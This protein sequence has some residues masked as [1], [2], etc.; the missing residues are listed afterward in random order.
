MAAF[1]GVPRLLL[2]NIRHPN[3]RFSTA[4]ERGYVWR[5]IQILFLSPA[6][7]WGIKRRRG[8]QKPLK[9]PLLHF[10]FAH[11]TEPRNAPVVPRL[12]TWQLF[13]SFMIFWASVARQVK[14]KKKEKKKNPTNPTLQVSPDLNIPYS[15]LP[16]KGGSWVQKQRRWGPTHPP[17]GEEDSCLLSHRSANAG[18]ETAR[19]KD[20]QCCISNVLCHAPPGEWVLDISCT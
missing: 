19:K 2:P 14:P 5:L 7:S 10:L 20:P 3:T 11:L 13:F 12:A 15:C 9:W 4:W 18:M 1:A 17:T 8:T 16:L 6:S